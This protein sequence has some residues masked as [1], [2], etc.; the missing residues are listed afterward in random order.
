MT[1]PVLLE[2]ML[3]NKW[4]NDYLDEINSKQMRKQLEVRDIILYVNYS[5]LIITL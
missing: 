1:D 4:M 2:K 5:I 3:K